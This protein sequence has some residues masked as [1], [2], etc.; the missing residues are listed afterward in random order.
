MLS[1][2]GL[3]DRAID[4]LYSCEDGGV[5]GNSEAQQLWEEK[6]ELFFEYGNEVPNIFCLFC[7]YESGQVNLDVT[8]L[9]LYDN[10]ETIGA[11]NI[12]LHLDFLNGILNQVEL[13]N[14]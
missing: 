6:Q 14:Q 5:F 1:Q 7:R 11:A 4:Y 8:F 2:L 10:V 13:Y 9:W 12:S 3:T